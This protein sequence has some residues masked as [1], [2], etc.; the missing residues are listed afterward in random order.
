MI[1]NS[2]DL[3][4]YIAVKLPEDDVKEDI[5]NMYMK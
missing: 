2:R 1:I 5:T 4:K 3:A